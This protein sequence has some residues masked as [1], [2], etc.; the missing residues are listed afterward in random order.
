MDMENEG[1]SSGEISEPR[2]DKEEVATLVK[3]EVQE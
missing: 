2:S 3:E 1:Y